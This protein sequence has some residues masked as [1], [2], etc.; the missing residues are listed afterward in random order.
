A[1]GTFGW[2]V[3][4][5]FYIV[6]ASHPGCTNTHHRRVATTKVLTVPPPVFNLKLVLGCPKLTRA[7]TATTLKLTRMPG[8]QLLLTARVQRRRGHGR[9]SLGG[10]IVFTRGRRFLGRVPVDPRRSTATL[11]V[12][13]S[14]G[15]NQRIRARY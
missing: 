13:G 15:R 7:R 3:L 11:T 10:T 1:E 4:P 6:A 14:G 8:R 2:D 9:A 12:T 5:G